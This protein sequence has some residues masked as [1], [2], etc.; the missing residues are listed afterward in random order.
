MIKKKIKRPQYEDY[1]LFLLNSIED[2][3]ERSAITGSFFAAFFAGIN[4][5]IRVIAMLRH[6]SITT[7]E[8]E[9]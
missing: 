9:G 8:A 3:S 6:I 1:G 5:P 2:C 7:D 4:P